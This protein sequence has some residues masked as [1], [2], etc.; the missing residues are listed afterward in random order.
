[1]TS[2]TLAHGPP[3][4]ASTARVPYGPSRAAWLDGFGLDKR[5]IRV[6]KVAQARAVHAPVHTL[7]IAYPA[8]EP[9][10]EPDS[11]S[12]RGPTRKRRRQ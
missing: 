4:V 3:A 6:T 11:S 9:G 10:V 8:S 1:M 12:M 5:F 7:Q 2:P